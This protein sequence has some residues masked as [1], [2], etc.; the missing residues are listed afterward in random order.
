MHPLNTLAKE[1]SKADGYFDEHNLRQNYRSHLLSPVAT[2]LK[3]KTCML[4]C[5]CQE[6]SGQ[7]V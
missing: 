5:N 6:A 2:Q 1:K 4:N 3:N 7:T